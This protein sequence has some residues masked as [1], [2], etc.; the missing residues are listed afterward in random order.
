M[1][2]RTH[3]GRIDHR[4][5]IVGVSRQRLEYPLPDATLA[6]AGV[7]GMDNA[8]IAETFWQV[9]PRNT[10]AV[11]I[12]HGFNKQAIIL[13]RAPHMSF[14]ARQPILEPLP[15]VVPLSITSCHHR[16]AP[17]AAI[18]ALNVQMTQQPVES[19]IDDTS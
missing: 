16:S 1:L 7:A 11:T 6:P 13:G 17:C 5:F 18:I 3:D 9:P 12:Q 2:M 15:L 10:C 4:V 19:S 14:P 8:E